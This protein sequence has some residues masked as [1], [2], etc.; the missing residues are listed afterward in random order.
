[1]NRLLSLLPGSLQRLCADTGRWNLTLFFNARPW[2]SV[3]AI[4]IRKSVDPKGRGGEAEERTT[5]GG[6]HWPRRV[7][8]E[9]FLVRAAG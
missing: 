4:W 3:A 9:S 6:A 2:P 8:V 1:M 5:I 7:P